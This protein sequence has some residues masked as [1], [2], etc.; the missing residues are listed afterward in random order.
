MNATRTYIAGWNMAGYLPETDPETF[1]TL[2]DAAAYLRETLERWL[3]EDEAPEDMT[4]DDILMVD[5]VARYADGWYTPAW[6]G[7]EL[8]LWAEETEA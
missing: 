7:A 1:E 6:G 3:D 8:H 5:P 2:E 4:A